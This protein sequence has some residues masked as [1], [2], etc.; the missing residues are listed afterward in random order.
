MSTSSGSADLRRALAAAGVVLLLAGLAGL[1]AP[2]DAAAA[3]GAA[4]VRRNGR[5]LAIEVDPQTRAPRTVRAI[6]APLLEVPG[7]AALSRADV[8]A[9]G[10]RLVAAYG[11]LLGIGPGQIRLDAADNVAGAWYLSYRQV[12]DGLD[13]HDS[14]LGFSIDPSGRIESLG[15]RLYPGARAPGGP[16]IGREKALAAA[17]G[18]IPDFREMDYGLRS[19]SVL[20]YPE[21]RARSVAYHRAYVFRFFPGKA[22]HPAGAAE[23]WAVYVDAGSGEVV[24]A[25]PLFKPLGCCLPAEGAAGPE[26][27]HSTK[28]E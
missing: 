20:I 23:G 25:Q 10:P 12:A 6:G 15:A 11:D 5:D 16:G 27:R 9:I 26:E 24:G 13:V 7:A 17:R 8:A 14:S 18:R 1:A 2:A 4:V 3:D 21:R 28:G 19:E 22:T